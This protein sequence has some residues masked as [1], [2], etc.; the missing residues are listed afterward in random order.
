MARS[1]RK[2]QQSYNNTPPVR[3]KPAAKA[4]RKN[5]AATPSAAI[6]PGDAAL[7]AGLVAY[8][9]GLAWRSFSVVPG[10][11]HSI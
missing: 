6:F 7:K 2:F 9:P 3:V 8:Y 11:F 10:T 1:S 5:P 4:I